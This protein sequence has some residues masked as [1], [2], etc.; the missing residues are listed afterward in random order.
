MSEP[1]DACPICGAL[2][3]IAVCSAVVE[4]AVANDGDGGQ[5][6]S[7]REVDDDTSQPLQFR[8]EACGAVF[9]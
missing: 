8:C 7:R 6:W 2:R 4:Y 5:D 9:R 1:V 3:M